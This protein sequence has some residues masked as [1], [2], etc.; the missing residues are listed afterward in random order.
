MP[1]AIH[2][3]K[4]KSCHGQLTFVL[5]RCSNL[6][7]PRDN[8]AM[9][10]VMTRAALA[11]VTLSMM[12][13][14]PRTG[15]ACMFVGEEPAAASPPPKAAEPPPVETPKEPAPKEPA[16]VQRA[17]AAPLDFELLDA[18]K[19]SLLVDEGAIRRRRTLLNLHQAAGLGLFA[20]ALGNTVVG[21][22]NYSDRFANGP[23][24]G[25]YEQL[26]KITA[27]STVVAFAATG[28]LAIFAPTPLPKTPGFDRVSWHKLSVGAAAAGIAAEV[29]LGIYTASRE[30]RLNQPDLA[31]VHL[32]IGYFTF[33]ALSLG[34]GVIVF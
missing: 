29:V 14:A 17:P 34:V 24:T 9:F 3:R 32:G 27:Y 31:A 15:L 5:F 1:S 7:Q 12:L 25:K 4:I 21:Q 18:P 6:D 13:A 20:I 30:G 33:A 26:H 11:A 8:E 19:P 2:P 28:A 10:A 22:L 23:S 16:E